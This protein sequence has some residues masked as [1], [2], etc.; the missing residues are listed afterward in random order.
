MRVAG[1][2]ACARVCVGRRCPQLSH[3]LG[4]TWLSQV[5]RALCEQQC[6]CIA[7]VVPARRYL[8]P[9]C[10]GSCCIQRSPCCGT[11]TLT[12]RCLSASQPIRTCYARDAGCALGMLR[13]VLRAGHGVPR[14]RRPTLRRLACRSCC[15]C[16]RT[17]RGRATRRLTGST[18]RRPAVSC[19]F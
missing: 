19:C 13:S 17:G 4:V 12:R 15:T 14:G 1:I 7:D 16:S 2:C 18:A 10:A 8:R 3:F 11:H 5:L 6:V 9:A